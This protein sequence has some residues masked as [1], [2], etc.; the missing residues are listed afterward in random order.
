MHIQ[1]QVNK[2]YIINVINIFDVSTI[3]T[4]TVS[5]TIVLLSH[6]HIHIYIHV[7]PLEL[8]VPQGQ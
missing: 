2:Q 3:N 5:D 7:G 6:T 4:K 8:A 1:C